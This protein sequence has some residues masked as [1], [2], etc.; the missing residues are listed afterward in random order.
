[1]ELV[2]YPQAIAD[3]SRK[4]LKIDQQVQELKKDAERIKW[5]FIRSVTFDPTSKNQGQRD[6]RLT[7]AL[8][9]SLEYQEALSKLE[10]ANEEK[11]SF[12][13][14]L[15]FLREKCSVLKIAQL[16]RLEFLSRVETPNDIRVHLAGLGLQGLFGSYAYNSM[17]PPDAAGKIFSFVEALLS[18]FN[19]E[20][21][22][23][24]LWAAK[25]ST[26]EFD[27]EEPSG[28]E[29]DG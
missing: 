6:C 2:D 27:Q 22:E 19:A 24:T 15:R 14:E 5:E 8:N 21:T 12:Q 17:D 13:I 4:Y 18:Q 23:N 20:S 26:P 1:M 7:E 29:F 11:S 10:R 25:V 3:A 9:N 28:S 16:A